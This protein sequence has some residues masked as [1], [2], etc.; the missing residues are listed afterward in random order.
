VVKVRVQAPCT[1]MFVTGLVFPD[2]LDSSWVKKPLN[3]EVLPSFETPVLT[4]LLTQCHIPEDVN[5]QAA[6]RYEYVCHYDGT[7]ITQGTL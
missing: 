3:M 6:E 4:E 1:V 2:I 5:P 7:I